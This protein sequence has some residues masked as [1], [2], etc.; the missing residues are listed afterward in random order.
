MSEEIR[1]LKQQ[2]HF[3]E[4]DNAEMYAENAV[5]RPSAQKAA[6]ADN[7][8]HQLVSAEDRVAQLESEMSDYEKEV[9]M[10]TS[11]RDAAR[12]ETN[13]L[14]DMVRQLTDDNRKLQEKSTLI[15]TIAAQRRLMFV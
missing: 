13:E 4:K 7:V 14:R 5:L 6:E 8:R 10:R 3:L 2:C 11:E 1:D 15:V 9:Q 12:T